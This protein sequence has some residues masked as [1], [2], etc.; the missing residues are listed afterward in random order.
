MLQHIL[1][2]TESVA[3]EFNLNTEK[4]LSFLHKNTLAI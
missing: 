1:Q 4:E 3:L 2:G